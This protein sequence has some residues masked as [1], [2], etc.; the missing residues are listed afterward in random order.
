M[1][2]SLAGLSRRVSNRAYDQETVSELSHILDEAREH[3]GDAADALIELALAVET[4][5]NGVMTDDEYDA[6]M[7]QDD[8]QDVV[9]ID[10]IE[11]SGTY[12]DDEEDSF[13]DDLEVLEADVGI[14][15]DEDD[16]YGSVSEA[17]RIAPGE[18]L[19]F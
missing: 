17:F 3:G 4:G 14:A 11:G 7:D 12:S 19:V 18:S 9:E 2:D 16:G 13:D 6:V 10:Y 5:A 8:D 1:S 15:S